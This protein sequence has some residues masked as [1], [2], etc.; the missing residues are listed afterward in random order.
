MTIGGNHLLKHGDVRI[1]HLCSFVECP[2]GA[3][4]IRNLCPFNVEQPKS[5][6]QRGRIC[7]T[8]SAR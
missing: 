7:G 8:E 6:S 2:M 4:G 5:C 1:V 3:S